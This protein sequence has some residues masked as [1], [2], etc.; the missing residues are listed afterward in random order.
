MT[1]RLSLRRPRPISNM[2]GITRYARTY[3]FRTGVVGV[4]AQKTN[5]AMA[6][7]A[8]GGGVLMNY[9]ICLTDGHGA[10]VAT[11]T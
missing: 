2:T 4:A 3:N 1:D 11:R 7:A 6:G 8:F 9:R 5:R 10:I